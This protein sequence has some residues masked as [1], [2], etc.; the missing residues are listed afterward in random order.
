M[1]G[2]LLML[3]LLI[4]VADSQPPI[5]QVLE[6]GIAQ[7]LVNLLLHSNDAKLQYQIAWALSNIASGTNEQ[8]MQLIDYVSVE[9]NIL[10]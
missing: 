7:D 1:N 6:L 3:L 8:T 9:W 4:M 5:E 2:R 10:I